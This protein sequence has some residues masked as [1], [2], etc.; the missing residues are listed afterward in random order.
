[1][2]ASVCPGQQQTSRDADGVV[3]QKWGTEWS[4]QSSAVLALPRGIGRQGIWIGGIALWSLMAVASGIEIRGMDWN[5][6]H[7]GSMTDLRAAWLAGSQ[8]FGLTELT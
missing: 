2:Q 7:G 6:K 4:W 3:G 5:M 8:H 1:M